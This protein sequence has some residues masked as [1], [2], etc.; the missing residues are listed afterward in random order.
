M[1]ETQNEDRTEQPTEKRLRE[2][3]EKGNVPRSRELA[4]V[5]VLGCAVLALKAT[6]GEVGSAARDWM[7]GAL[8]IDPA[9]LDAPDQL[10]PHA[11]RLLG[12]LLLPVVPLLLAALAACVIAPMVMGGLRFAGQSLQPD[13]GR[14]S[15]MKGLARLYGKESLAELLRSLLRVLLIGGVGAWVVHRAFSTLL[16]MPQ[17]SLEA[18]A[19]AGVD[20]ALTALLAMVGA[21]GLLAAIDVPWQHFQHRSKLKMTKQEIRDEAKEAEGNPE[22]KARVRQVAREMSRRRMMDAVPTAD[23]VVMNPTHYAVALKYEAGGMRAPKVVAK[24][25]DEMALAIRALAQKNRVAV[26][27]APPL[28]RALYRQSQVDQEIPVKLYAA[29]AQV[30]SYVYQL[31]A[32]VP[33]RGPMPALAGVD[34]GADGAPDPDTVNGPAL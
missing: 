21:L 12:G 33:G 11:A 2:A 8:T 27:E 19:G 34:V 14:L 16:A 30:L 3:R 6:G 15:P 7:R 4:N 13:F 31:K 25:V 18:A 22:I 17:A 28:A 26:V 9:L 20:M 24:G 23:V 1:S 5:A 32:W 29:V 10:L